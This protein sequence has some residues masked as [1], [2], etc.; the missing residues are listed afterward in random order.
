MHFADALRSAMQSILSHKMRS[1]LTLTGIVIGVLAVVSMFSSV[2]ALKAL[3]KTN[4]EGMGWNYSIVITA[5]QMSGISGPRSMGRA[6][7]RANQSQQMISYDD[8]LALKEKIPHKSIYGT[9]SNTVLMRLGNQDKYVSLRAT[10]AEFFVNKSYPI[11]RG[12]YYN[13]YEN[14]NL[15]PVAVLGSIFARDQFGSEDPV[16]KSISLGSYRFTVVGVLADDALNSGGG[17]NFNT[18]ERRQDLQSVYVP[19]RY[20]V[21][22]FGTKK[23]LHMIYM[24]AHDEQEFR[25]MKIRARQLLLSR[26]NMFPNFSF[27]DI[28]DILLTVTAEM[29][30]VMKKWNITL[31]AIAS[32]SLIV[33]G[34]G[35]FSTLLISIQERMTEIGVRKSIGATEGD[36]F[37]YFIFESVTLA[38]IG[39][40]LG[41][42]SAWLILILISKAINFPL[43]LPIQG[44]A[45]GLF[46]SFLVGVASG[47][48]PAIKAARIDPIKAIYYLE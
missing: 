43:Y 24:Q 35:L 9:I 48:Y 14:D 22:H 42:F 26:H 46:F 31:F 32:I 34:I 47:I 36:I 27:M 29:D 1:L 8:L 33:G 21:H 19:L 39:A 44:V 3:V 10:D 28:G 45:V 18:F 4:M 20:G 17:M 6:L 15:L 13:A 38:M 30:S 12:R 41:I 23:G 37:F 25:S 7:R 16:G 40:F 2:Y 5:G 11:A